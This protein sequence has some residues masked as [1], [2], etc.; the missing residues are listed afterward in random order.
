VG[1]IGDSCWGWGFVLQNQDG[2]ILLAGAKHDTNSAGAEIEEARSCPFGLRCVYEAG[3]CHITIEGDNLSLIR[4][5]QS[6][7]CHNNSLGLF[8]RFILSF[9]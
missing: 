6:K 2:D 5:F 9:V 1:R 7:S 4:K 3:F 8:V